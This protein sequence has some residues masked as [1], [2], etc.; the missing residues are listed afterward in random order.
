[1]SEIGSV[2]V[3]V[4]GV[5]DEFEI[6]VVV[7]PFEGRIGRADLIALAGM[8]L[9][10]ALHSDLGLPSPLGNRVARRAARRRR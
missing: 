6:E 2:L 3:T 5:G 8:S 9:H 4:R 7:D 1:V 10:D